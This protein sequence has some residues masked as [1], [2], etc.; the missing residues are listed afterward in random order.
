MRVT[1][2]HAKGTGS[3]CEPLVDKTAQAGIQRIL[4]CSFGLSV[5][6]RTAGG[7]MVVL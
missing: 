5:S 7:R 6:K 4:A 2:S 1:M 3:S